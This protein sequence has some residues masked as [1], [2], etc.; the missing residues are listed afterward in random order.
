MA[1]N[2]R[3][4]KAGNLFIRYCLLRLY[5]LSE[6]AKSCSKDYCY[7]WFCFRFCPD[8]RDRLLHLFLLTHFVPPILFIL[9]IIST[10]FLVATNIHLFCEVCPYFIDTCDFGILRKSEMHSTTSS[11]ALPFSGAVLTAI[12]NLPPYSPM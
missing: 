4:G 6:V 3:A 9:L 11:F 1:H 5:I 12:F 10:A 7:V 8:K 2:G